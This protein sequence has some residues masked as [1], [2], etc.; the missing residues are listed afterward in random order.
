MPTLNRRTRPPLK[1]GVIPVTIPHPVVVAA[2]TG[3]TKGDLDVQSA[4]MKMLNEGKIVR[5]FRANTPG[6]FHR[7]EI[8]EAHIG[9][10]RYVLQTANTEQDV[11]DGKWHTTQTD[12][13]TWMTST[14]RVV[15]VKVSKVEVI[16]E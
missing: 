14:F 8:I 16:Y 7:V 5:R 11:G 6:K 1:P 9:L 15:T 10:E 2:P 12:A 13:A 4:W 3:P